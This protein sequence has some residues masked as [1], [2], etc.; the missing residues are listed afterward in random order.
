[1]AINPPQFGNR[2]SAAQAPTRS[3]YA[4]LACQGAN[5]PMLPVGRYRVRVA[6]AREGKDYPGKKHGSVIVTLAVINSDNAAVQ[7]GVNYGMVHLDTPK[8]LSEL[9]KFAVHAAGY[10]PTIAQLTAPNA[11]ALLAAGETAY[12]D[13]EAQ[14]GG[15]GAILDSTVGIANG[16]PSLIGRVVDV[17]VS[18]GSDRED[19]DYFRNYS[20]GS[21]PDTEQ[22]Q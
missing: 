13:L 6:A 12:G 11:N 4:G 19:G 7:P 22:G 2:T 9:F 10:G 17:I 16:A 14:V 18:R 15:S 1:M 20:W 8:G 5:D 21:V 3:K